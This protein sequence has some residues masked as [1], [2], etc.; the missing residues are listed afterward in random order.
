MSYTN[1]KRIII[2][3]SNL[4]HR[5]YWVATSVRNVPVELLFLN[6]IKKLSNNYKPEETF[7]VWDARTVRGVK[8]FRQQKTTYKG[9]RD[10]SKNE[11][12]FSHEPAC[13]EVTECLGVMHLNP[14]VLEADDYIRWLVHD[15][16]KNSVIVSSDGDMIQ[17]VSEYTSVLN[18]ITNRHIT[19]ENFTEITGLKTTDEL[20]IFKCLVGDKS[21]NIAGLVGVGPKRA[22]AI[23][24]AGLDTLNEADTTTYKNNRELIDLSVAPDQHPEEEL[25]LEKNYDEVTKSRNCDPVTFKKVCSKYNLK[26]AIASATDYINT[27]GNT[28]KSNDIQNIAAKLINE[29]S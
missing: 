19:H 24:A 13:I 22:K 23:M 25:R 7:V 4:L 8:N 1:T 11:K 28:S 9:T 14:G 2:D 15:S 21:D 20:I 17:L 29:L 27:I 12:V 6:S 18:P 16:N 10:K 3:G 26:S 5:C